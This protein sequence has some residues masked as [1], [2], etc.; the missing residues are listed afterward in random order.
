MDTVQIDLFPPVKSA[1]SGDMRD[2]EL[3]SIPMSVRLVTCLRMN[4]MATLRD[5][6]A[7]SPMQ[8][9]TIPNF[10]I[11]TLQE[12]LDVLGTHGLKLAT[13]PEPSKPR[14]PPTVGERLAHLEAMLETI[15]ERLPPP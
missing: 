10:G 9:L 5:V 12:L 3:R 7:R 1:T 15:L 14:R 2:T 13:D 4:G 8:L 6:V 11:V